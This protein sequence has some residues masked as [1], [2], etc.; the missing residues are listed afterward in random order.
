MYARCVRGM[1]GLLPLL[2]AMTVL[3][4]GVSAA[5]PG[6]ATL[7]KAV[8]W[9]ET[10][11]NNPNWNPTYHC[12]FWIDNPNEDSITVFIKW[13]E[14]EGFVRV[15]GGYSQATIHEVAGNLVNDNSASIT[16]RGV[17]HTTNWPEVT[18]DFE[19]EVPMPGSWP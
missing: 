18:T 19:Q 3:G 2:L 15:G 4:G 8:T 13:D 11:E 7:T 14:S 1:I 6:T 16:I 12:E 9:I 5:D 10:D 17:N